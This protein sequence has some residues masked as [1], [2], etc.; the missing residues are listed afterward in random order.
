MSNLGR[1]GLNAAV[2]AGGIDAIVILFQ[3]IG[4]KCSYNAN[5]EVSLNQLTSNASND[6]SAIDTDTMVKLVETNAIVSEKK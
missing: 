1:G 5:C 3:T 6:I 2:E 4:G